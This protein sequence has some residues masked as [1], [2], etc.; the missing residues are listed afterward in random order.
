MIFCSGGVLAGSACSF[1]VV[2][3]ILDFNVPPAKEYGGSGERNFGV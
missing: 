3:N 1:R 2:G